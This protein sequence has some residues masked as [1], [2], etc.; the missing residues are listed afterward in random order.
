MDKVTINSEDIDALLEEMHE[1]DVSHLGERAT[2]LF[3][4]IMQ[5]ADERDELRQENQQL[6]E[7]YNK[8][9]HESTEFESK[10]YELEERLKSTNKGLR[11]VVIK[12]KKWKTR[13][14]NVKYQLKQRDE[15]ID[16]LKDY[17]SDNQLTRSINGTR[18][19]DGINAN[20]ELQEILQKYKGDNNE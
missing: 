17:I 11:K 1:V 6:K 10:V 13:Y 15:V 4:A 7:D 8:V 14:Q 19:Y 20:W 2:K 16:K 12:R 18:I 3:Y 9:V 5:I